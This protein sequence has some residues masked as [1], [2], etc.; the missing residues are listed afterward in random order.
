VATRSRRAD[1]AVARASPGGWAAWLRALLDHGE[2]QL[3]ALGLTLAVGFIVGLASLYLF[4]VLSFQVLHKQTDLLD[5]AVLAW[6]EQYRSPTLDLVARS[7]SFLGSEGLAA[8][9]VVLVVVFGV[10]GR[11]GAAAGVV[12]AAGGAQLLND[13]LKHLF[14]RVRPAPVVGMLPMQAFSYPSGHAMVSAAFYT[15]LG[16][17]AWRVLHGWAR[18]A[19]VVV[20]ATLILAIGLS[21]L[22]LGVHYLTDVLAGY[23][24]GFLW[25]E[26]VI[27]AGRMV[28]RRALPW[29]GGGAPPTSAPRAPNSP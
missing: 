17:V 18:A 24:A 15:F 16:Y 7:V 27:L 3:A 13:V 4:A 10:R 1:P 20:L 21:R 12:L 26:A 11:W 23:L 9:A 29:G 22:Y 19:C 14:Q 28:S 5:L 25:A 2:R 8:L 6:L